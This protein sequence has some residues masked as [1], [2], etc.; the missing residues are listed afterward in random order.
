MCKCKAFCDG[1]CSMIDDASEPTPLFKVGDKVY[2]TMCGWGN[3]T[4]PKVGV[5]VEVTFVEQNIR[6]YFF[7]DGRFAAAGDICLF[8]DKPTII[9]AKKKVRKWY[10]AYQYGAGFAYT[11]RPMSEKESLLVTSGKNK[12]ALPWTEIEELE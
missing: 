4:N 8:H 9:P 2:S 3:V 12:I 6:Y 11:N 1:R 10:W 5:K 7:Q